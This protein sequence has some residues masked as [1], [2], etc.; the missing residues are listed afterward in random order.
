MTAPPAVYDPHEW[1]LRMRGEEPNADT[2]LAVCEA[3]KA[4]KLV[5]VFHDGRP[6]R[7]TVKAHPEHALCGGNHVVR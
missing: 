2:M 6:A 4:T 3:C 7:I 5:R 1:R